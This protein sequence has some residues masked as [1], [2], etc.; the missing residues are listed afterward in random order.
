MDKFVKLSD[1]MAIAELFDNGWVTSKLEALPTYPAPSD[2]PCD[3]WQ[4]IE[5]APK[6]GTWIMLYY[7]DKYVPSIGFWGEF[8]GG[9]MA[10]SCPERK[11]TYW[12]HLPANPTT[13]PIQAAP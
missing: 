11:F 5:T 4:P 3:G 2:A 1:V 8:G 13:P 9:K 6:D 10:W 12:R 7:S